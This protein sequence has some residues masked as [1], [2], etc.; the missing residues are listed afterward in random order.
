MSSVSFDNLKLFRDI[1][2][3]RSFSRGA[4]LNEISQSAA[5]QQIQ[6]V[7]GRLGV[8][9]FDR[10]TRP[11]TL[12]VAGKLYADLCRDVLRRHE[13]FSVEI[14]RLKSDVEGTVRLASIY[15]VGISEM[16]HL[17]EE[18]L[19]R[20]PNT[21]LEVEYLQP[22]NVYEAVLED[23]ADLGLVSYPQE[24]RQLAVIP[25]RRERMAVAAAPS[26]PLA[27]RSRVSAEDL[28]GR[29]FVEFDDDLP[30]KRD[31]DRFLRDHGI[32]VN[33]VMHFDNVQMV[34][35]AVALS[36]AIAILPERVMRAEVQIGRLAAI[37]LDA[38][39][40]RPVGIVH[41]RKRKLHRAAE[42]FLSLL[43]E[44]PGSAEAPR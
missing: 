18:F 37:P 10:S 6:E 44:G 16:S 31:T 22:K 15:S 36:G 26:D 2:Q 40:V 30:I 43:Q 41:R 14:E 27:R 9:L 11:F 25:W 24:T 20:Y 38:A 7:E 32:E 13:E 3:T 42:L 1:V 17:K 23:R 8:A 34:K 19:R 5:S 33:R 12:T 21:R 28:A 29:D 35:E 4:A 39:L